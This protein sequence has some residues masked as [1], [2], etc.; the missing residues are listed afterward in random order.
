MFDS[1]EEATVVYCPDCT[2]P[3]R[4]MPI[5]ILRGPKFSVEKEWKGSGFMDDG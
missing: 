5:Y 1:V 2:R 3:Q 4:E